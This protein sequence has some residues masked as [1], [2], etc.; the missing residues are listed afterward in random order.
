MDFQELTGFP[1]PCQP[2]RIENW[3]PVYTS[4]QIDLYGL[5]DNWGIVS[6]LVVQTRESAHPMVTDYDM[7]QERR[8]ALRPVHHYS[9]LERFESTLYQLIGCRGK[10]PSFVIDHI[11]EVG[12]DSDPDNIWESVQSILKK[13]NWRIYYNRIPTILQIIGFARKIDFKD[14]S[15]LL[16]E[17]VIDFKRINYKFERIK[18]GLGGRKYFPSLRFIAF[19]LL[20]KHGAVFQYQIPFVRTPRKMKMLLDLWR[21]INM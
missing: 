4:E 13:K 6:Y 2:I 1:G 8:G 5:P 14:N 17:I 10:V 18:S 20:E 9:R 7:E 19:K 21:D 15:R 3:M 11:K 16:E 12:Y